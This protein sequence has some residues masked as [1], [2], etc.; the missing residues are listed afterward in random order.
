MS[1][2][3]RSLRLFASAS[4]ALGLACGGGGGSHA[5]APQN[6]PVTLIQPHY[7]GDSYW[8]AVQ[9]GDGPWQV[10]D[11][12]DGRYTFTVTNPSGRYAVALV[13]VT[14]SPF[15]AWSQMFHLTR[16][17]ADTI[18]LSTLSYPTPVWVY[19]SVFGLQGNDIAAIK[20]HAG[21]TS[22]TGPAT[23]YSMNATAGTQDLVAVRR[24]FGTYSADRLAVVRNLTLTDGA[25][26]ELNFDTQGIVLTPATAATTG[27]DVGDSVDTYV[28]WVSPTTSITLNGVSGGAPLSFNAVPASNLQPQ[29]LHFVGGQASQ[30]ATQ[31]YARSGI[32]T[33]SP[34]QASN[35]L[36]PKINAPTFGTALTSP[37]YRPTLSWTP[38]GGSQSSDIYVS[39][40]TNAIYWNVHFSAGWLAG[41]HGSA[42]TFPDFSALAGWS[43][44]WAFTP[45][46]TLSWTFQNRATTVPTPA[47]YLDMVRPHPEGERVWWSWMNLSATATLA[48]QRVVTPEAQVPLIKNPHPHSHGDTE[49]P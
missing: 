11:A 20:A 35:A 25:L 31:K 24:P 16:A 4:L 28:N 34:N 13:D 37:Y 43:N 33:K 18:D 9:D 1:A 45:G 41:A 12:V 6:G 23:T 49:A 47:F 5:P 42:F 10:L 19:G 36:K 17:E 21:S 46:N 22:I 27:G 30:S 7:E 38:L 44:T 40:R 15:M 8:L 14:P 29:E 48:P 32:Y 26:P 2:S 3:I 39:D